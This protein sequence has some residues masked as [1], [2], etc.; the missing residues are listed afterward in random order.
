VSLG[1]AAIAA[2]ARAFPGV[3]AGKGQVARVSNATQVVLLEKGD[4]TVVTVWSDY[5]GPLDHFALVLP[6]PSDVALSEVRTLKRD[7]V[8]HLDEISAPRFHEFWEMDP[9]E[10]GQAEQEWERDLSVKDSA[11]N[12][13][14]TGM[15]DT[16]NGPKLAPELLLDVTPQFKQGEYAFRMVPK[17]Q[18]VKAYLQGRQLTLPNGAEEALHNYESKG[19]QILVAE[20]ATSKV[21][22]AGAR[23]SRRSGFLRASPTPFPRR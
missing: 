14:G 19:M 6:V 21:E 13:L 9:C 20:V 5:E 12:F 4:H 1:L 3:F 7:P 22:L 18:S 2:P 16:S 17:G 15:P 23:C 11:V 10:A 8:D